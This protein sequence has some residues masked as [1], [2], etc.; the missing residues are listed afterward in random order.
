MCFCTKRKNL[1]K[2]MWRSKAGSS[3]RHRRFDTERWLDN[4][5]F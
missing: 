5:L 4:A 2:K 3:C 1:A